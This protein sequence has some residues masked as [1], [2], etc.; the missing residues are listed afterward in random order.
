MYVHMYIYVFACTVHY[1][2][3]GCCVFAKYGCTSAG[4]I[5]YT[6]SCEHVSTYTYMYTWSKVYSTYY[7]AVLANHSLGF[8]T[9][10]FSG[11]L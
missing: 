7:S 8:G 10:L 6:V 9:N 3:L 1:K 4:C 5:L 2:I 11:G